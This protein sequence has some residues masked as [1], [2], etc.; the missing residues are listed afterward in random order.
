MTQNLILTENNIM[1]VYQNLT[2]FRLTYNSPQAISA[3][4]NFI[5]KVNNDGGMWANGVFYPMGQ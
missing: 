3:E 5:L 1:T 4:D 2:G